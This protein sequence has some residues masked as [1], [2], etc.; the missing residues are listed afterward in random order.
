MSPIII[1]FFRWNIFP[2]QPHGSKGENAS[3]LKLQRKTP[4]FILR[5]AASSLRNINHMHQRALPYLT[6]KE[7]R[8]LN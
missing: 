5:R 1:I 8:V 2:G 4:E 3:S 6:S 7:H